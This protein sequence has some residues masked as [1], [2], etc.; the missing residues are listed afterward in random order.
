MA[1]APSLS[2]RLRGFWRFVLVVAVAF[3]LSEAM[4]RLVSVPGRLSFFS[5]S[6][7]LTWYR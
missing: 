5:Q 6:S 1:N 7:A 2:F 4:L 3:G